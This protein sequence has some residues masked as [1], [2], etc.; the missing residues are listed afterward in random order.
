[1]SIIKIGHR[2]K[3][4]LPHI[5]QEVADMGIDYNRS[6][7]RHFDGGLRCIA[8]AFN[9]NKLIEYGENKKKTNPFTKKLYHD[10]LLNTIHAEADLV[11]KLLKDNNL[12]L[13][14]DII[15][16]RG[17]AKPLNSHPCHVC[18]GLFNMYFSNVRMWSYDFDNDK[19]HCELIGD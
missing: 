12:H 4:V 2:F 17:T 11:M 3:G 7:P 1:M 9:G 14:T 5:L 8:F 18:T 15:V 19:W 10:H 13:V 16:I 6:N